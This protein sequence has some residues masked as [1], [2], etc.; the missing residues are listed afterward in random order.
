MS[1]SATSAT[2]RSRS[3]SRAV[4]T[5]VAAASSHDSVLVPISSVTCRRSRDPASRSTADWNGW[6]TGELYSE[7]ARSCQKPQRRTRRR[8]MSTA[9]QV[10]I[11]LSPAESRGLVHILWPF[12][13][14]HYLIASAAGILTS[15]SPRGQ[16]GCRARCGARRGALGP[17]W[18]T[19]RRSRP[20]RP[21]TPR[22]L[23]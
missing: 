10:K 14:G 16:P 2:L 15:R 7:L 22:H 21:A 12:L 18:R 5:A 17:T 3:V 23:R 19:S 13:T 9:G 6:D 1:C 4:L 20:A 8:P 11:T